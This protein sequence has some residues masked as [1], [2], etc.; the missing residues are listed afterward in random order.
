MLTINKRI[1]IFSLAYYPVVGGAEIAVKEITQRISTNEIEW[2]V[3]TMRFD[4]THL[5]QEK[6]G[7]CTIY[8]INT[9]KNLYP[10]KALFLA[11]KLHKIRS[12]DATWAI[13]ANWA[14]FAAL[15][16]KF[17][18]PEIPYILTL[19]EGDPISYIKRK[20]WFVCP[21]FKRIFTRANIVQAISNY[22]A[23]WAKDM[24]YRGPVE[25]IPN[26]V[27]F[28]RF[29]SN[30]QHRVLNKNNITLI[31]TSRLVEKNGIQD[32][33]SALKFLP[34]NVKLKI[35]GVG[36]LESKLKSMATGLP[37]EFLGFV[38][39]D[40]IVRYLHDADIFIRPSL[41]EGQGISFI[42]AMAAGLPVIATPVGGIPD[43]LK[44][45][46]NSSGQVETGLFCEVNNPKSIADKVVEYINNPESTSKIVQNARKMVE[47]KYDWNLIAKRMKEE[48][49][50]K[51]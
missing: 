2:D 10:F 20:V 18:F 34:K 49:F 6:I 51:V 27:D 12:Y 35:L 42:E 28:G 40:D 43:F 33:I 15:F 44:D 39:Q 31:T 1:L 8:R 13:M 48:I 36:P 21:L 23:D 14:G 29:S 41:S 30:V 17:R 4:K 22:L 37:V 3:I 9:S 45:P 46:S 38:P 32:I 19:Q 26:G 50:G 25:V 5:E 47:E 7:N 24:G 16:F 11:I